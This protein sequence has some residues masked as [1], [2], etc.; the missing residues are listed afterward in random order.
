D[1]K[2]WL[3][4]VNTD[5]RRAIRIR[6]GAKGSVKGRLLTA[7]TL[8]AHNTFD[9]PSAVTPRAYVQKAGKDGLVLELPSKSLIVVE[10][11]LTGTAH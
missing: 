6:I 3:A 11:D 9:Q 10:V 7:N 5:P 4:V 2:L 8:D 1:G